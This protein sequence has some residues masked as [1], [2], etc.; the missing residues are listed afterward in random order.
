MELDGDWIGVGREMAGGAEG[1]W[2]LECSL[3]GQLGLGLDLIG[4]F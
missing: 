2:D 3:I 4:I 1:C